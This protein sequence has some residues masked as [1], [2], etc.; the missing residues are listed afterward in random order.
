V[1]KLDSF[2]GIIGDEQIHAQ[3]CYV[4]FVLL[5][6]LCLC[7]P[8]W[9]IVDHS[10]YKQAHQFLFLETT[11][12]WK[13]YYSQVVQKYTAFK[14]RKRDLNTM[15]SKNARDGMKITNVDEWLLDGWK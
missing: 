9:D 10:F 13:Q 15:A 12:A 14:V 2:V 11:V 3:E 5:F 4:S 8:G 1:Y 7:L 6:I